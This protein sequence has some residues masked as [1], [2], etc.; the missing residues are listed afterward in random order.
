MLKWCI[1]GSGDVVQRLVGN[2]LEVKNKSRIKCLISK[3]L[4]EA[5][6]YAKKFKKIKTLKANLNN[7]KKVCLDSEIDSIYI[8]TPPNTHFFYISKFCR[9]KK[10]IVCEK[11]LVIKK[12]ELSDLRI[13]LKKYKFNLFTCFYRRY[14][15]RFIEIKKIL[16][17]KKLGKILFF[18]IKYFHNEK[19][20]PT[21]NI[22]NKKFIPWRFKKSISGGGNIVD[23]GIHAIDLINFFLGDIKKVKAINKNQ[24]K[25]YNVDDIN[26]VNFELKNNIVG[27]GSWCSTAPYK[28]DEFKIYGR[29]GTIKFKM[30]FG[31]KDEVEIF[32]KNKKI[33]KN[34]SMEKPL[35]K[36]MLKK[37]INELIDLNKFKKFKINRNGLFCSEILFNIIDIKT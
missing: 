10:N 22:S 27:Q 3:D 37:F 1:I 15:K 30:N 35:H 21:A 19:N 32:L 12:K 13:L 2:S 6:K 8:A 34:I 5:N 17:S 14:L 11:P 9:F 18:E 4:S 25:F 7:I 24:M 33:K 29:K 28:T 36:K 31:E 26:L 23:M 20:H 16:D